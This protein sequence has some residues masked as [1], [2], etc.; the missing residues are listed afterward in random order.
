MSFQALLNLV[1]QLGLIIV[2]LLIASLAMRFRTVIGQWFGGFV[3]SAAAVWA[4]WT[5]VDQYYLVAKPF[6]VKWLGLIQVLAAIVA[7][8]LVFLT[9]IFV[10][11]KTEEREE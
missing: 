7:G 2:G 1:Y 5:S 6:D 9:V 4:A 3:C 11:G 8:F 10:T